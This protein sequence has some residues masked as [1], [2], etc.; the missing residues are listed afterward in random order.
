MRSNAAIENAFQ[1][2]RSTV[3]KWEQ[4]RYFQPDLEV[5]SKLIGDGTFGEWTSEYLGT[6]PDRA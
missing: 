5:V 4:E 2:I 3:P 6:R 1:T